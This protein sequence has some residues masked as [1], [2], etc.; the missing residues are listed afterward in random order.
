[1]EGMKCRKSDRRDNIFII[2]LKL[3]SSV[4]RAPVIVNTFRSVEL[5]MILGV[6]EA[7]I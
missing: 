4:F 5:L 7:L 3:K 6:A 1:M 2:T